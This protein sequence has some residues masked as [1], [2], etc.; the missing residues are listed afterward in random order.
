[1]K[2]VLCPLN[3]AVCLVHLDICVI[4]V[5]IKPAYRSDDVFDICHQEVVD[6]TC[7]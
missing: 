5:Q 6:L 7:L 3:V 2:E 1:M 4:S